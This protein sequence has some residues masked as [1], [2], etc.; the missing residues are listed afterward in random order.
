LR[1]FI[2]VTFGASVFQINTLVGNLLASMQPEGSVSYLYYADRLVQFPL[3]IFGIATATAVLPV[4]SQQV[5]AD[6]TAR[7]KDTLT[8][9]LSLVLFILTPAAVGLIVLREP[10][11]ALLFQRGAFGA[12]ATRL[13]AQALLYYSI[14]LWAFAA[15]RVVLTAFYAMQDTVTPM[16]AAAVAV[17]TNILLGVILMRPMGHAGLALALS[18][19]AMVN[20][21]FLAVALR[22]KMGALGCRRM[23]PSLT[24][25]VIGSGLMGI[26]VW[27]VARV[28]IPHNDL[29]FGR[30]LLGLTGSI[31]VGIFVYGMAAVM[32]RCPELKTLGKLLKRS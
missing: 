23:L 7:L 31:V 18:L 14:G 28:M 4:L 26:I 27:A 5:A 17:A 16:R 8:Y 20:F 1:L 11:V 32:M 15:V 30:L 10:I 19:S 13:T 24:K 25:S 12:N 22:S 9:S 6:N 21:G 2:P 29:G 3:G